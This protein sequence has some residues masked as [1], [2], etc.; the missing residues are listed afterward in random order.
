MNWASWA[1]LT[2]VVF[3]VLAVVGFIVQGQ[4]P[5]VESPV[6]E[7]VAHYSDNKDSVNT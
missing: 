5:D 4:P 1:P 2:G 7:I 6:Q 3:I